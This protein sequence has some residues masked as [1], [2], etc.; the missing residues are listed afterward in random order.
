MRDKIRDIVVQIVAGT[1][2]LSA[3]IDRIESLLTEINE[4]K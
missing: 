3:G 1:L 4:T 2:D